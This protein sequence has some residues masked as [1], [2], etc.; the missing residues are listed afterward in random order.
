MATKKR[1]DAAELVDLDADAEYRAEL[2]R[3]RLAGAVV[4][5]G[6][7]EDVDNPST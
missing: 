3:L 1:D 7:P 4:G 2:E 6:E 5:D